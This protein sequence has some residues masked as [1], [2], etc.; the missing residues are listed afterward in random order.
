MAMPK[1]T[2]IRAM[3]ISP[4]LMGGLGEAVGVGVAADSVAM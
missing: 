1:A 3:I 4:P 2:M